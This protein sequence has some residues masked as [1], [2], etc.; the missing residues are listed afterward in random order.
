MHA[1]SKWLSKFA[2]VI[3]LEIC[4]GLFIGSYREFCLE[5]VQWP[6]CCYWLISAV[7]LSKTN[8]GIESFA[9]I[10]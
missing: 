2:T 5:K 3:W 8:S 6:G 1:M 9:N 10:S 7:A 4:Y